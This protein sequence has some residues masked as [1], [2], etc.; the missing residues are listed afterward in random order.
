MDQELPG[1]ACA[2]TRQQH[3]SEWNDI[4]AAILK[5]D[6]VSEIWLHRSMHIYLKNNSARFH[7]D[8]IWNDGALGFFE[9]RR[10][11]NNKKANSD[12]GSVPDPKN[13]VWLFVKVLGR[14]KAM[15]RA[16]HW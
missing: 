15:R 7:P 9:E 10:P 2:L 12:M 4:M 6:V 16:S 3:F 5:Y 1:A 11:N 8:P 13:G 14:W